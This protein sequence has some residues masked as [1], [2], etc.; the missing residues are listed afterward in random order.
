MYIA[1]LFHKRRL[2]SHIEIIV[3]LLP[4]MLRLA[5]QPPRDSLLQR[6]DRVG[7][8]MLLRFVEQQVNVFGHDHISV[9]AQL[10]AETHPL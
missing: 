2:I 8:S 1:Q 4:E 10:E 3:A 9:D 5:N 6:L 7:Q